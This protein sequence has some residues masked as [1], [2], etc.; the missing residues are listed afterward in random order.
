MKD[1]D[2]IQK[3]NIQPNK[4]LVGYGKYKVKN[5]PQKFVDN[6]SEDQKKELIVSHPHKII[7]SI[8]HGSKVIRWD[9]LLRYYYI[10]FSQ[11]VVLCY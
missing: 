4:P 11:T 7:Q 10:K 6:Y 1:L 8:F 3:T 5:I 9:S 2:F